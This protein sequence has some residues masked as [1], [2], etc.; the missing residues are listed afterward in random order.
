MMLDISVKGKAA[1][2]SSSEQ[3]K[4]TIPCIMENLIFTRLCSGGQ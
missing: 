3:G 1:H 4:K 2:W